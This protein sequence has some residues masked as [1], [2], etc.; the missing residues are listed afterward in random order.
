MKFRV[1]KNYINSLGNQPF[2]MEKIEPSLSSPVSQLVTQKQCDSNEFKYWAD[3]LK[4]T[5]NKIWRKENQ[6]YNRKIWEWVY[7]LQV[8]KL[9]GLLQSGVRGLGF[10]VGREPLV[11]IMA[12]L[13]CNMLATDLP[14]EDAV[15]SGW[16][17]GQYSFNVN[18]LNEDIICD[19]DVFAD[20]VRFRHVDM[21]HIDK[22]LLDFDF[23]YSSCAL[24]HL[25]SLEKGIEFIKNSLN[26]IKVGGL[27]IHTTEFNVSSANETIEKGATVIYRKKDIIKLAKYFKKNGYE[28]TLNFSKGTGVIDKHYDVP[29]YFQNE[30]HLKL[31]MEKYIISSIGLII[32][33]T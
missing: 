26:C 16:D 11:A 28:M 17:N 14:S 23:V 30:H 32:R 6:P 22:D 29:P 3:E 7:I 9:N 5:V 19:K 13:G 31:V 2:F 24:E 25:G 20:R 4:S 18:D 33:K 10:G 12:K 27:A 1:L 8:L 21:N 15:R